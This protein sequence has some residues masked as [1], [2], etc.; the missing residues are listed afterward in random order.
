MA[1]TEFRLRKR[2]A[3]PAENVE[4]AVPEAP[5]VIGHATGALHTLG[6]LL[7]FPSRVVHGTINSATGGEGGFGNLNPFDAT[8]GIEASRH[9]IRAGILPEND[10]TQWE[11]SDLTRGLADVAGDPTTWLGVGGLTAAG[12]AAA[13]AG[14]LSRGLVPQ[15]ARGERALLTARV[16]FRGAVG[17][18]GAGPEVAKAVETTG[19]VTRLTPALRK[20]AGSAPVRGARGLLSA[21]MLGVTHPLLQPLMQKRFDELQRLAKERQAQVV[22]FGRE[23]QPFD[24]EAIRAGESFLPSERVHSA[25]EGVS[26]APDALRHQADSLS[27]EFRQALD[28]EMAY[29]TG[30]RGP[31]ADEA[32]AGYAPRRRSPVAGEKLMGAAG[33]AAAK[34][35]QTFLKGFTQGTYAPGGV[36]DVLSKLAR[37][38]LSDEMADMTRAEKIDALV[39]YLHENHGD[40]IL[41]TYAT[42]GKNIRIEKV[43]GEWMRVTRGGRY[44]KF[45]VPPDFETALRGGKTKTMDING[46][47]VQVTVGGV[48]KKYRVGT[49][50]EK[51][52]VDGEKMNVKVGERIRLKVSPKTRSRYR[53]LAKYAIDNPDLANRKLFGNH[54][55]ADIGRALMAHDTRLVNARTVAD[56]LAEGAQA[57]GSAGMTLRQAL[58]G[59]G[60]LKYRDAMIDQIGQRL[61]RRGVALPSFDDDPDLWRSMV[62]QHTVDPELVK[63]LKFMKPRGQLTPAAEA[64]GN[65]WQ[66][67]L[68]WFKSGVLAFPASRVRDLVSGYVQNVLHG[69]G[70]PGSGAYRDA[71]RIMR[72]DL[73]GRDYSHVPAVQEWFR[74]RGLD[75]SD[76]AVNT[77][78]NQT[79][80]IRQLIA[81]NLPREHGFLGDFPG[82]DQGFTLGDVL[83]NVP[84]QRPTTTTRQFVTGPLETLASREPGA[85]NPLNVRGV[86][87]RTETGFAP[88][89]SAEQFSEAS[90]VLNRGAG[91]LGQLHGGTDVDVA[92]RNVNR[93]QIMY[94]PA[95]Y[96]ATEKFLKRNIA[97]FYSFTTRSLPET[98]RQVADFGSPTSQLIKAQERGFGGNP[99]VP[100]YVLDKSGIPLQV[101]PDGTIEVLS[102]LGLMHE[103]SAQMLGQAAQG[104]WR[105]L[106]LNALAQL[107][108]FISHPVEQAAQVSFARGGEPTVNLESTSGRLLSNMAVLAGLR[109]PDAGPVRYPGQAVLDFAAGMTPAERLMATARQLTDTRRGIGG[110]V[111]RGEV[112]TAAELGYELAAGIGPTVSGLRVTDVSPQKQL[113]TLRQRAEALARAEGARERR[114]VY[115]P[116][117]QLERLRAANP[118]LAERQEELKAALQQLKSGRKVTQERKEFRLRKKEQKREEEA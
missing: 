73:V 36:N 71:A 27:E 3:A 70:L 26:E 87:G 51:G 107:N 84:G 92:A 47:P 80:A 75:I 66:Q 20:V 35:R 28:R 81:V 37:M 25:M 117:A 60:G 50:T 79:E 74:Q 46:V 85:W 2:G 49:A 56:A 33:G 89:K 41:P 4:V 53:E 113:Q 14:R 77:A 93:A 96:S 103:N 100:D 16:P 42:R 65:T 8:G 102:G 17:H 29:G 86:G 24:E 112:P 19:R 55:L 64:A 23:V 95:T 31:L 91:F 97:P 6:S 43:G 76:P 58:K 45:N 15:I 32:I 5:G 52:L 7:S 63:Q 11:W 72:G 22:R 1:E 108:P 82:G 90:D 118:E 54:M 68:N 98:A 109:D 59:K 116:T 21:A 106:G 111:V 101:R 48:K 40:T 62:L 69:W 67:A 114:D 115:F 12:E 57:P 83:R 9:L 39:A 61:E 10:P 18:V 88:I 78:A 34:K 99:A 13:K 104:D 44:K 110:L 94:D 38:G 105:G 30:W